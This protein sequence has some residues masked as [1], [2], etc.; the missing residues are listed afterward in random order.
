MQAS[1]YRLSRTAGDIANIAGNS[2]CIA[3]QVKGSGLLSAGG[4]RVHTVSNGDMIIN[5]SDLPYSAT[6][7]N[8][9]DFHYRMLKIPVADELMLGQPAHDLFATRFTIQSAFFRPF[10][11]LFNALNIDHG[12]LTDPHL[13]VAHI[14]RLAMAARG[15]LAS[16]MPE[17]RAAVGS[18][19]RYAA[20]EIMARNKHRQ[21]LTPA[22]VAFE[23]GISV[24]QLY[25]VFEGAERT[26]SLTLAMTRL[27]EAKRL[28]AE[29]P[30][31]PVT[32]VA[33]ACGFDSLATFYRLFSG[34][35]G[36]PPREFRDDTA[37][38]S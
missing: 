31:L 35:F 19:L 12:K 9:N 1:A 8:D 10:T 2:L 4:D 22:M 34:A 17:V 5:Y 3:V 7:G 23:L 16:G 27:E 38:H 24:R 32:Q 11:A 13:E 33:Y 15:R 37:R 21:S 6:P 36:M 20:E 14:T 26:F 18:G 25:I 28:L 29:V 30:A